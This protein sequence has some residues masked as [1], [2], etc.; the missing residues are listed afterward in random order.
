[1]G[2]QPSP[3]SSTPVGN[4]E[5]PLTSVALQFYPVIPLHWMKK[6][7]IGPDAVIVVLK[8]PLLAY[9]NFIYSATM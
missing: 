7:V 3:M 5:L 1:M 2:G 9:I 8:E 4:P 6:Y